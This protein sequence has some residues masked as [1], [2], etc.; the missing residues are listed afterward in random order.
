MHGPFQDSASMHEM[1]FE[2]AMCVEVLLQ[3]TA[4]VL[5][6]PE[7]PPVGNAHVTDVVSGCVVDCSSLRCSE[8]CS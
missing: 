3:R 5:V 7:G 4:A 8:G 1:C 6:Q 2:S